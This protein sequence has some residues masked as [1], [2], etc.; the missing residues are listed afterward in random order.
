MVIDDNVLAL[1][2]MA[3][4]SIE[5]HGIFV[6]NVKSLIVQNNRLSCE[7][8]GA[9]TRMSI[10][11][12]RVYGFVGPMGYVTRNE[13][14]GFPI[15]IRFAALNHDTDGPASMWRIT[16]NIAV[17]AARTVD[18]SLRFG[19]TTHVDDPGNIP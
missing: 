11:G 14:S 18:L 6:G 3:E 12:I 15:G 2:L 5:R 13:M 8:I 10:D 19:S 7:R 9:A 1:A 17:G 4:S 16:D